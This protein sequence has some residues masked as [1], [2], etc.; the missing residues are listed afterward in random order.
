VR[1]SDV[2]AVMVGGKIVVR[3]GELQGNDESEIMAKA[4]EW[5]EKIGNRSAQ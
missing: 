2:E 5:G 4:K 3:D 1:A